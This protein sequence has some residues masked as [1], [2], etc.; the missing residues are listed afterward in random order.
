MFRALKWTCLMIAGFFV[1]ALAS[2]RVVVLSDY[3]TASLGQYLSRGREIHLTQLPEQ[4]AQEAYAALEKTVAAQGAFLLRQDKLIAGSDWALSGYRLGVTGQTAGHEPELEWQFMGM[5]I[6][7]AEAYSRLLQ[8]KEGQTLGFNPLPGEQLTS[9]P[10]IR[11][12]M[13]VIVHQMADLQESTK[14]VTGQYR[15]FGLTA[16]AYEALVDDLSLVT[17]QKK[18]Q[19]RGRLH[20]EVI[21]PAL[22]KTL[23]LGSSFLLLFLLGVLWVFLGL[24]WQKSYGVYALLG[25]SK[26]SFIWQKASP[27]ILGSCFFLILLPFISQFYL[28]YFLLSWELIFYHLTGIAWGLL[29]FVLVFALSMLPFL[30]IQPLKAIKGQINHRYLLILTTLTYLAAIVALVLGLHALDGPMFQFEKYQDV[31]QAWEPVKSWQVF[32]KRSGQENSGGRDAHGQ[33]VLDFYDWYAS[34]ENQPGVYLAHTDY[35]SQELLADWAGQETY[36]HLPKRPFWYLAASASYLNNQSF[37]FSQEDMALAKEGIRIYYLPKTW[38]DQE[39]EELKAW[40]KEDN[41][42]A[43]AP[44][45]VTAFE[46]NPRF[47]FREYEPRQEIFNF[48]TRGGQRPWVRDPVIYLAA[49]NNMRYFESESLG[50][51]GALENSYVKLSPEASKKYTSSAYLNQYSLGQVGLSFVSIEAFIQGLSKSLGEFLLLFGSIAVL[52]AFF[53]LLLIFGLTLVYSLGMGRVLA[54][55]RLLGFGLGRLFLPP[56]ILV[57][58]MNLGALLAGILLRSRFIPVFFGIYLLI[59]GLLLWWQSQKLARQQMSQMLK[60]G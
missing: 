55:K 13:Q 53:A 57:I 45:I 48:D 44:V 59:Q 54:V 3:F 15:V 46:Q 38:S 47:A 9:L 21:T 39:K 10:E 43:D 51:S 41:Q 37:V 26:R 58:V 5:S 11:G 29:A 14:T 49:A 36:Q 28:K 16:S 6:L 60:E 56:Y 40:L 24:F 12:S 52:L 32:Y 18:E 30:M 1:F 42:P 25:W 33:F 19:L 7:D 35:I 34:I 17:G 23:L 50:A 2:L 4:T 27:L 8:A 31:L 20:G 22:G